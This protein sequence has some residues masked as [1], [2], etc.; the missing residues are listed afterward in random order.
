M[1]EA[2]LKM[3]RHGDRIFFSSGFVQGHIPVI[4]A[5]LARSSLVLS[6]VNLIS[7]MIDSYVTC[8]AASHW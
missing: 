3:L 1:D 2:E 6:S 5:E 7:P 8:I 4:F